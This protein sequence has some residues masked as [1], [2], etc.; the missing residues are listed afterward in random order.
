M[1]YKF[2]SKSAGTSTGTGQEL[3]LESNNQQK[4]YTNQL[5]KSLENTKCIQPFS[6][7]FGVQI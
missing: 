3:D 4:N 1:V 7:T 2:F 6:T 5:L